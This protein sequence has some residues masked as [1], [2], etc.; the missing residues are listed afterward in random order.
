MNPS[1]FGVAAI[2]IIAAIVGYIGLLKTDGV[3][4]NALL[5]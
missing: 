5:R 1:G 3:G 2:G 4:N